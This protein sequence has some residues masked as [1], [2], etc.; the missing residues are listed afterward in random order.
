MLVLTLACSAYAADPPDD[1]CHTNISFAVA[2]GGSV[3]P[4]MPSFVAKWVSN[5]KHLAKHQGMCFSQTPS[6]SAENYLIVFSTSASSFV[7]L[8]PTFRTNASIS[9]V[10]GNGTAIDNY[11]AM[12][13]YAY[14]GTV[15]TTTTTTVN[16]PYIDTSRTLYASAYNQYGAGVSRRWAT[17][18][19]RQGGDPYNT[20]GYNLGAALV[21]IHMK[22]R[23]LEA[24][25]KEIR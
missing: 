11:G 21:S 20:L 5:K 23:L 17:V 7:G 24:T 8:Y 25:L 3:F 1:R 12:W 9:S 19:T 6:A 4:S 13:S 16:A 22:E 18:K 2:D 14:N 15:T 10:S